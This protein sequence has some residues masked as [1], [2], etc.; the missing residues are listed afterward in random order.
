MVPGQVQQLGS[1][2]PLRRHNPTKFEPQTALM[3]TRT[4]PFAEY[5]MLQIKMTF[6]EGGLGIMG[7]HCGHC[8]L[9]M[10]QKDVCEKD[11]PLS[12]DQEN[13]F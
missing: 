6:L 5:F 11:V 13:N 12:D 2:W 8:R 4:L 3:N 10:G 9:L 1:I 7:I